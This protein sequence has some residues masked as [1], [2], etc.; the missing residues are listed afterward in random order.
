MD[1][2]GAKAGVAEA[3]PH[4]IRTHQTPCTHVSTAATA[5]ARY[6]GIGSAQ[7]DKREWT[8]IWR[9]F[10]RDPLQPFRDYVHEYVI[11]GAG[12]FLEGYVVRPLTKQQRLLSPYGYALPVGG[13]LPV[14]SGYV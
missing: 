7:E 12:L 9:T 13:P 2:S 1:D 10:V 5:A 6:Q 11:T 8:S 3:Y 4:P 14:M